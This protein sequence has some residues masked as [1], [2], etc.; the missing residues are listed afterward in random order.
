METTTHIYSNI[1]TKG[2]RNFKSVETGQGAIICEEEEKGEE[3]VVSDNTE[4]PFALTG[5]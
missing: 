2:T 3:E 5:V 4:A 1:H